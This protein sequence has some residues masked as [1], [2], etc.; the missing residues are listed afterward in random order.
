MT[1]LDVL[2]A[3]S[4]IAGAAALVIGAL[5]LDHRSHQRRPPV[6]GRGEA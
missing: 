6:S 1:P 5:I 3:L 4:L 2:L